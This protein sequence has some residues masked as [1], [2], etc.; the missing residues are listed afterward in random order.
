MIVWARSG[1]VPT[2][3]NP[4]QTS[5][6]TGHDT[7]VTAIK[8]KVAEHEHELGRHDLFEHAVDRSAENERDERKQEDDKPQ[9]FDERPI[10]LGLGQ[11]PEKDCGQRARLRSRRYRARP[12]RGR[13]RPS[14]SSRAQGP[15]Q[16][17]SPP[18]MIGSPL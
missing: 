3:K 2:R 18:T 15:G 9:A 10:A 8:R 12:R 13:R 14:T 7:S 5:R 1:T 17:R 16:V 6:M 4:V 11:V